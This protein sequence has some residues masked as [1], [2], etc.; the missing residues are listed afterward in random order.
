MGD[1]VASERAGH[2]ESSDHKPD[3]PGLMLQVL[4]VIVAVAALAV[5]IVGLE[6]A[7][8]SAAAAKQSAA[9][10]QQANSLTERADQSAAQAETMA[11]ARDISFSFLRV[12][13]NQVTNS[14][15]QILNLSTNNIRDVYLTYRSIFGN[16]YVNVNVVKPCTGWQAPDSLPYQVQLYFED[17]DGHYWEL[18][19]SG[20][21]VARTG[22]PDLVK[23]TDETWS[24]TEITLS[25]AA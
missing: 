3:K 22:P 19:T 9:A 11:Q 4:M 16:D 1:G 20:S 23:S 14:Y 18:N 17:Q 24:S 10:A 7:K 15:V 5:S 25:C 2:A 8:Q 21:L 13:T 6:W 12:T